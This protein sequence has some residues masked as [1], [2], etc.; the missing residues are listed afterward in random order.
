MAIELLAVALLAVAS[1]HTGPGELTPSDGPGSPSSAS[2]HSAEHGESGSAGSSGDVMASAG[3]K[4]HGKEEKDYK[5]EFALCS[6]FTFRY[7]SS[8]V[9]PWV[10][11]QIL[12]GAEHVYLYEDDISPGWKADELREQ[13]IK[14]LK[15]TGKVTIFSMAEEKEAA[16]KA[17]LIRL[18]KDVGLQTVQIKRCNELGA[19]T[20]RWMGSWDLDEYPVMPYPS[21]DW[22]K[23]H[24]DV[25]TL[26]GLL[27]GLDK[28]V[29]AVVLPRELLGSAPP[30]P[31][32]PTDEASFE[33]EIYKQLMPNDR[34]DK[35]V[36]AMWRTSHAHLTSHIHYVALGGPEG[37]NSSLVNLT[38]KQAANSVV[39]ADGTPGP[40]D[41]GDDGMWWSSRMA[42]AQEARPNVYGMARLYHFTVRSESE[43]NFKLTCEEVETNHVGAP[44]RR[45]AIWNHNN[46]CANGTTL[47]EDLTASRTAT[48]VRATMKELYGEDVFDLQKKLAAQW[49]TRMK[50]DTEG[51]TV[52]PQTADD[53]KSFEEGAGPTRKDKQGS[54]ESAQIKRWS[55]TGFWR[56][57]GDGD[58]RK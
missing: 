18:G 30:I 23:A 29:K 16:E 44:G 43:C 17:H 13:T 46:W 10:A 20:S 52:L 1:S 22:K 51:G 58:A 5:F 47:Q 49:L 3:E 21:S 12:F 28:Q 37:V 4:T 56:E 15:K 57:M 50:V 11:H 55:S 33:T 14:L 26:R 6:L 8:Y 9:L 36:K 19:N 35:K 53:G 7:E 25:G 45:S 48:R 42:N 38:E 27:R 41:L 2:G 34:T 32:Y 54:Q 40:Y 39:W 24:P 31:K